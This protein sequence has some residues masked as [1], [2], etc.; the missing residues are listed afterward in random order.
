MTTAQ[1][2][3]TFAGEFI[4]R[5]L[6]HGSL[7]DGRYRIERFVNQGGKKLVFEAFDLE[8]ER[9]VAIKMPKEELLILEDRL[10]Q[11][12]E[13]GRKHAVLGKHPFIE[14]VFDSGIHNQDGHRPHPYIVTEFIDGENLDQLLQGGT[15][16]TRQDALQLLDQMT[17]ALSYGHAKGIAHRDVKRKNIMRT[18]D[19]HGEVSYKLTDYG[20]KSYERGEKE[21]AK[22][23][24]LPNAFQEDIIGVGKTLEDILE[25]SGLEDEDLRGIARKAQAA[26]GSYATID[27]LRK[28]AVDLQGREKDKQSRRSFVKRLSVTGL[29]VA[30]GASVGTYLLLTQDDEVRSL[31]QL[32]KEIGKADAQDLPRLRP[33]YGKLVHELYD[34]KVAYWL[35]KGMLPAGSFLWLEM[36]GKR[37]FN[38]AENPN[39][40]DG[41][42]VRLF[43]QG[44]QVTGDAIF[45]EAFERWLSA[46]PWPIDEEQLAKYRDNHNLVRYYDSHAWAADHMGVSGS[47]PKAIEAARMLLQD[48][49]NDAG[50]F[51]S[52]GKV[53]DGRSENEGY[54]RIR[55]EMMWTLLPFLWWQY[56]KTGE[57]YERIASHVRKT[58][59][60]VVRPEGSNVEFV[61]RNITTGKYDIPER[62]YAL[63]TESCLAR[64]IGKCFDG[65]VESY[66]NAK[67]EDKEAFLPALGKEARFLL[68]NETENSIPFF[69]YVFND[70]HAPFTRKV[71]KPSEKPQDTYAAALEADAFLRLQDAFP[72]EKEYGEAAMRRIHAIVSM[73]TI[74][75]RNHMGLFGD[76]CGHHENYRS[77]SW[78]NNDVLMMELLRKVSGEKAQ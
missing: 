53:I 50:F 62:Y 36:D 52:E 70:H 72:D 63:D 30:L 48:R 3:G 59:E 71:V 2:Q 47:S 64:G 67:T 37:W 35:E 76:V 29:G 73:K 40:L 23:T 8:L 12:T 31:R 7:L 5:M 69:D 68:E 43:G 45:K 39:G 58:I 42:T 34:Q 56:Q 9:R 65:L 16:F 75:E 20:R 51:Q 57:G 11:F 13:E 14:Q 21:D 77:I 19:H 66:R 44:Y 61:R 22:R 18:K 28:D 6:P 41:K 38:T 27:D 74:K 78:V 54:D 24:P 17:D 32:S 15:R 4:P 60:A 1:D 49:Y 25:G 10:R 33:L 26:F 46:I 55:T